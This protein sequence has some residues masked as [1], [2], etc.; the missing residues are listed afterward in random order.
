MKKK[1]KKILIAKTRNFLRYDNKW[2]FIQYK[3]EFSEY[4]L[5]DLFS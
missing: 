1:K 4:L 5:V 2:F 3:I